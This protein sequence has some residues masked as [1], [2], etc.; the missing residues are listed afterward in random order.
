MIIILYTSGHE[1]KNASL[2]NLI[3]IAHPVLSSK[4][5][6]HFFEIIFSK[7]LDTFGKKSSQVYK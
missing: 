2:V 1:T 3:T 7:P 6:T 5:F 4:L